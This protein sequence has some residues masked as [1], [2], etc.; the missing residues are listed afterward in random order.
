M[1]L[2]LSFA[3]CANAQLLWKISGNGLS[4]SSYIFGTHH[5][6]EKSQIKDFDKI[7][8]LCENS[9]AMVGEIVMNDPDIQAK[10]MKNALIEDGSVKDYLNSEDFEFLDNEFRHTLGMG[11]DKLGKM[12]PMM[13]GT[14]YSSAFYCQKNK[15][16]QPEPVDKIFQDKAIENGKKVIGLETVEEQADILFNKIPIR[17]QAELLVQDV[18]DKDDC[19][20]VLEKLNKAYLSGNLDKIEIFGKEENDGLTKDEIR[21]L[22]EERNGKWMAKI[23][24][25]LREQ[26]CFIAVGCLHLAGKSGI[27]NQLKEAG[28]KVEPVRF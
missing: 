26:S 21:I 20:D 6:I 1:A 23:P 14:L 13:L 27:L 3:L 17:R 11:L 4:K 15:Q 24:D 25:L 2:F 28:Y 9:D 18:R 10:I 8:D 12:K 16:R 5:M 7:L 19:S 22:D